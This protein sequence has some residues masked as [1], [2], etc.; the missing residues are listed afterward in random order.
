MNWVD[1][2]ES[3]QVSVE[4]LSLFLLLRVG[5]IWTIHVRQVTAAVTVKLEYTSSWMN[6]KGVVELELCALCYRIELEEAP[7]IDRIITFF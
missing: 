2:E 7:V 3:R 5:L 6:G 4:D 1:V